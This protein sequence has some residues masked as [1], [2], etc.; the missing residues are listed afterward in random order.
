MKIHRCFKLPFLLRFTAF[1]LL[2]LC[3]TD[4][5]YAQDNDVKI[6]VV[7]GTAS[8]V[9]PGSGIEK[10]F[11]TDLSTIYHSNWTN[12]ASNYFPISLVYN[13]ETA[14]VLDYLVYTPRTT[15]TNGAFKEFDLYV[16]TVSNPSFSFV[17]TYNFNGVTTPSRIDFS[18]AIKNPTKVMFVVKSGLGTGQ[19]FA[20][21]AEMEF[22]YKD[23]GSHSKY[24]DFPYCQSFRTTEQ[25]FEIS[26]PP[27]GSGS[28]NSAK[29]T[30]DGVQLTPATTSQF[31]AIFVNNRKFNTLTGIRLE[32]EYMLYGGTGADGISVF[33]FDASVSEP[34]IGARGAGI[35][36]TQ[37]RA[38]NLHTSARSP[39]LT[40]GYLGIA[41]DSYGNFKGRR[42]QGESRRNG[43]VNLPNKSHVTL[44]GAKDVPIR[45]NGNIIPG[46]G[47]G[48]TGYPV[49]ITQSTT[50]KTLN[51]ILNASGQYVAISNPVYSG[52][53]TIRGGAKFEN[54]NETSYRKAI[55]ELYPINLAAPNNGMYVTVKIQHGKTISTIIEDYEYKSSFIYDENSLPASLVTGDN[56]T[57]DTGPYTGSERYRTLNA[58]VPEFLRIGFAGSTGA[59]TDIH[60]LKNLVITL[61]SSAEAYDDIAIT[62]QGQSV[63]LLPLENDLAYTG[64]VKKNQIGS[65]LY[66]NPES[67][68]FIKPDGTIPENPFEYVSVDGIWEY[69]QLTR[70]VTFTPNSSFYGKAT[71][72]YSIKGGIGN[73]SPY[74]DE[75]Y[76]SIPASIEVTVNQSKY[77]ISN[78]MMNPVLK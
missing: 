7:S 20:S 34:K 22:F 71:V 15:G 48:Y 45:Y 21:C 29:F 36:Y 78:K 23:D 3:L 74:H 17:D 31:G 60:L 70:K 30:S 64:T 63:E 72:Q 27:P 62:N 14:P 59:E 76:R 61:P 53:F 44:R 19:G 57:T 1:A 46:L 56:V 13:L 24:G 77:V 16:A 35:G 69:N 4:L 33:F 68:R 8:S 32:F 39:G 67:F 54:E 58:S 49:L 2:F 40:G 42:W 75:A 10:S 73:E 28:A 26:V 43:I 37:N 51:R 52:N 41:F 11:D 9:E 66:I 12:T 38:N 5:G 50:D 25:P 18:P 55:I 65:S 47:D 6:R